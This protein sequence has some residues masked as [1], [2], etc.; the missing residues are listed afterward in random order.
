MVEI[1][2]GICDR[3]GGEWSIREYI[4]QGVTYSYYSVCGCPPLIELEEEEG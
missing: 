3:C 2:E 4:I 1:K